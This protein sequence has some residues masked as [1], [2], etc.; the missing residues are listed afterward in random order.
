MRVVV[1]GGTGH[2]GVGYQPRFSSLEGVTDSL[3]WLIEHGQ[4]KVEKQAHL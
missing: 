1:I 2:V 3:M 4:L